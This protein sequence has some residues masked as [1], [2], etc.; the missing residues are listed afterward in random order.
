MGL[1][2]RA[3][4][5]LNK[6]HADLI[7]A[8]P[9]DLA[10]AH[11]KFRLDDEAEFVGDGDGRI[12]LK[13]SADIGQIADDAIDPRRIEVDPATLKGA[14]TNGAASVHAGQAY[15]HVVTQR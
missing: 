10:I 7:G 15:A 11:Q 5:L 14:L 6:A 4:R 2:T 3:G 8:P 12:G 13:A 9:G 1:A